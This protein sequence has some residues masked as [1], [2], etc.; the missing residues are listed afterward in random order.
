MTDLKSR[1]LYRYRILTP[2]ESASRWESE[3]EHLVALRDAAQ[4]DLDEHL[5]SAPVLRVVE[6]VELKPG[7]DGYADASAVFDPTMYQGTIQWQNI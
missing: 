5:E 2:E 3:Y 1:F 7:D 4:R 6:Q